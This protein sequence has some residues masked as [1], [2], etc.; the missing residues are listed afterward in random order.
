MSPF[1]HDFDQSDI[2]I[3]I[4][5]VVSLYLLLYDWLLWFVSFLTGFMVTRALAGL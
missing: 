1:F 2:Y 3:Y 4:G 5:G